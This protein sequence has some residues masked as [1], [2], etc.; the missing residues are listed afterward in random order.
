M[1]G[2]LYEAR[3]QTTYADLRDAQFTRTSTDQEA[4]DIRDVID[5]TL[6]ATSPRGSRIAA[7]YAK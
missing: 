4:Q 1:A 5:A 2:S 7:F 6:A 3:T